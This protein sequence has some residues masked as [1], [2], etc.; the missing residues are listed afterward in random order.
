[1]CFCQGAGRLVFERQDARVFDCVWVLPPVFLTG[2]TPRTSHR[3][4]SGKEMCRKSTSLNWANIGTA[5]EATFWKLF[6][7]RM[8]SIRAFPSA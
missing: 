7:D 1:M 3:R 8:E 5:L 2:L 4:R 6:R